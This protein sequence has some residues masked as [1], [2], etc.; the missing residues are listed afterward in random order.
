M[1]FQNIIID[2][3]L[4]Q[5]SNS[6]KDKI[7][8]AEA[9]CFGSCNAETLENL[10]SELKTIKKRYASF[11]IP[12]FKIPK[13]K[14][15]DDEIF[16]DVD[17]LPFL[18][19]H[20]L[21]INKQLNYYTMKNKNLQT[22]LDLCPAGTVI[23]KPDVSWSICL[24]YNDWTTDED[25]KHWCDDDLEKALNIYLDNVY[26]EKKRVIKKNSKIIAEEMLKTIKQK[27][28]IEA[29]RCNPKSFR[30]INNK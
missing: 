16:E 17:D 3:S 29:K 30:I 1:K 9:D 14:W 2:G 6:D 27:Y 23:M 8:R 11:N 15:D 18:T 26:S 20:Y 21:I 4:Y 12:I 28:G 24:S 25:T 22:L 19:N 10:Y 5:I 13:E 7:I